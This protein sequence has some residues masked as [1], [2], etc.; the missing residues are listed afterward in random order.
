[1]K[2]LYVKTPLLESL[3]LSEI[4]KAKVYLKMEAVQPSGSFKNRGIGYLCD[5]Y[6]EKEGAKVFVS[7]SGGNAGL[8][9]AHSGRMLGV[10]VKVVMPITSPKV[11]A[12]KIL[13]E[14]AEVIIEGDDISGAE[15][16]AKKLAK[17]PGHFFISPFDHPL[18][19]KGHSS[20]VY[21]I[22]EDGVKPN[23]IVIAVGGAGLFCGV[24]QGLHEIGWNDVTVITSQTEG[25]AAFAKSI[26]AGKLITLDKIDTVATSLGAKTVTPKA[27]ELAKVHPVLP[28]IVSDRQAVN[29]LLHFADDHRILVEPAC[30]APLALVYDRLIDPKKY[31]TIVIV[32]CGG[33]GVSLSLL[34]KWTKFFDI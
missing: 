5:H 12:E 15:V 18:I 8:A 27:L 6:A 14:G 22:Q 21:E 31:R 30:G 24:T 19:W 3:E 28:Y 29:A 32:V 13:R 11:M 23:A 16:L 10:R 1:M 26:E 9:V 20:L 17:K 33:C 25:A 2:G 7:A 4:L 34:E